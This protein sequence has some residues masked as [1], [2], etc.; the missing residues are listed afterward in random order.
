M[1]A[2]PSNNATD[3]SMSCPF[4]GTVLPLNMM[5][6]IKEFPKSPRTVTNHIRPNKMYVGVGKGVSAIAYDELI[7][8][9]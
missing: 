6:R 2:I 1:R 5:V 9:K 8:L 4:K 7:W 3:S